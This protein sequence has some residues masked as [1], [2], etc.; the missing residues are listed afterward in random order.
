MLVDTGDIGASLMQVQAG[1]LSPLARSGLDVTCLS[2]SESR[3]FHCLA[4][5][6]R[7][8]H[9]WS[10]DPGAGLLV[11][12]GVFRG[13]AHSASAGG[14][15][16]I[17]AVQKGQPAIV[18]PGAGDV[19]RLTWPG[20]RPCTSSEIAYAAGRVAILERRGAGGHVTLYAFSAPPALSQSAR[21]AN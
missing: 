5:D 20:Q 15:D 1:A 19:L 13:A 9:V 17:V 18:R 16:A 10:V 6:G 2:R 11:S 14:I 3:G 4:F 12:R 21:A 8:T 7:D